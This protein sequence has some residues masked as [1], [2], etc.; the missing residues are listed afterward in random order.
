MDAHLALLH[1]DASVGRRRASQEGR[2]PQAASARLGAE[3]AARPS[4]Q[5][6]YDRLERWSSDWSACRLHR[7]WFAKL[8]L[9][10]Y[11]LITLMTCVFFSG[12]CPD[13]DGWNPNDKVRNA[14]EAMDCAEQWLDV[15]QVFSTD[16]SCSA[17]NLATC[18]M[19]HL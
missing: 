18:N 16:S 15:P 2:H 19:Y 7:A 17:R 1:L 6:L 10:E 12:L 14:T 3:Q 11:T 8:T 5:Q 9:D 4:R 13:W